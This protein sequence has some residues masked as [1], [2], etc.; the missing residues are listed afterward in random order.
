[1]LVALAL[2]MAVAL[3]HAESSDSY[4][5]SEV[6]VDGES[7][8][9]VV[10]EAEAET[11]VDSGSSSSSSSNLFSVVAPRVSLAN[12]K[13]L[14]APVSTSVP[15]VRTHTYCHGACMG[16]AVAALSSPV[17]TA[18]FERVMPTEYA[19]LVARLNSDLVTV[20]ALMLYLENC[21][22]LAAY[23]TVQHLL[24]ISNG[25]NVKADL[26]PANQQLMRHEWDL[27]L[28]GTEPTNP[29]KAKL[30]HGGKLTTIAQSVF[31]GL[32]I[33]IKFDDVK[34]APSP[35][36]WM[37]LYGNAIAAYR[38]TA[39]NPTKPLTEFALLASGA[40][41]AVA[42]PLLSGSGG[43]YLDIKSTYATSEQLNGFIANVQAQLKVTVRGVGTFLHTQLAKLTPSV[44]PIKFYHTHYAVL[45]EYQ[46]SYGKHETVF[47]NGGSLFST[48]GS[49][50]ADQDAVNQL[51]EVVKASGV[52]VG[53]YV[54]EPASGAN[55]L[56]SLI[57]LVNARAD[58]FSAGFAY[59]NVNGVADAKAAGNGMG[60]QAP[61][62]ILDKAKFQVNRV[63]KYATGRK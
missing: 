29:A 62:L 35:A 1:M 58:V 61:L 2:L 26:P 20:D 53:V 15:M 9:S 30:A 8:V 38:F 45:A 57:K 11:E 52:K 56:A 17:W 36:A 33:G 16:S 3:I 48:E 51:A 7:E 18:I 37:A 5:D 49:T 6:S 22:V 12:V 21:P 46:A 10:T 54:Q 42:S 43:L 39:A 24:S 31:K 23:G 34:L 27:W 44:A 41:L 32:A 50:V 14:K 19:A 47:F 60:I 28:D 13:L 4:G 63:V 40:A 25:A 55:Y 59:G